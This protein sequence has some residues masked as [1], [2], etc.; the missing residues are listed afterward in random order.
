M[1]TLIF[2]FWPFPFRRVSA[3]CNHCIIAYVLNRFILQLHHRTSDDDFN[4]VASVIHCIC[5]S[6]YTTFANTFSTAL[7]KQSFMIP[8]NCKCAKKNSFSL[9]AKTVSNFQYKQKYQVLTFY[10]PLYSLNRSF[11]VHSMWYMAIWNSLFVICIKSHENAHRPTTSKTL[12]F[13]R[14]FSL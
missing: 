2:C 6:F 4:L 11:N 1:S 13:G 9:V 12:M 3:F 8:L 7:G 10:F 5:A 14:S